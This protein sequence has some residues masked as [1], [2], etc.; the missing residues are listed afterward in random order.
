MV[1]V[2]D[3]E[4]AV[5]VTTLRQALDAINSLSSE[6]ASLEQVCDR[7]PAC[8]QASAEP[9]YCICILLPAFVVLQGCAL[10]F[11]QSDGSTAIASHLSNVML[12]YVMHTTVSFR[13]SP[14]RTKHTS[15]HHNML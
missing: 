8:E 13:L 7:S 6:R 5:V 14:D 4:P 10:G 9:R 2:G 12:P 11:G 3:V 15:H 1:S